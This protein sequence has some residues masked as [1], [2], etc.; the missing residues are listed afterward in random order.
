[1]VFHFDSIKS[2]IFT[3][4]IFL[5]S[6]HSS[7]LSHIN[8]QALG[9]LRSASVQ[10]STYPSPGVTLVTK[11]FDIKID[12]S[13][14]ASGFETNDFI[15]KN[16]SVS[17]LRSDSLDTS[18]FYATIN[19][20]VAGEVRINIKSG[21]LS[22][23]PN[24]SATSDLIIQYAP[25]V[26][27]PPPPPPS[28]GNLL[29][30]YSFNG[31]TAKDDSGN[32]R[33]GVLSGVQVISNGKYGAALS[34]SGNSSVSISGLS[35]MLQGST[36]TFE[37]FVKISSCN[38]NWQTVMQKDN[39]FYL[40]ACSSNQG[41]PAFGL[42]LNNCSDSD[43]REVYAQ[44]ALPIGTWTHLAGTYDGA[45]LKIYINGVQSSSLSMTGTLSLS[46]G[47]LT[48]GANALSENFFGSIDE[49][50]VYDKVLS[51]SE[52]TNDMNTPISGSILPP[53]AIDTTPPTVSITSPLNGTLYTA[54]NPSLVT[55]NVNANDNIGISQ[56]ELLVNGNPQT[57]D[58]SPPY[59]FNLSLMNGN[60]ELEAKA[61]DTAGNYNSSSTISI[62]ANHNQP[63]V[64]IGGSGPSKVS[65]FARDPRANFNIATDI[66]GRK[67]YVNKNGGKD[68]C[69]NA[70]T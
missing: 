52:I 13:R 65:Q 11:A 64:V 30:S 21:A 6:S 63:P 49:V 33:N 12:F 44:S 27:P 41:K 48:I 32:N 53:P 16:A 22:N 1:M 36:V 38:N 66:P 56:V 40:H 14:S 3:M 19:P 54:S 4:G 26:V 18:L 10:L 59:S 34:F 24:T 5:I 50:R 42:C 2:L 23:R 31:G 58:T 25:I 15:L 46:S 47:P 8:N 20:L 70:L 60:Y 35:N 39:R 69:I 68:L 61:K 29:S 28:N 17:N 57:P 43:W 55:V 37:A 67:L 45:S 9:V 62:S 7:I 51:S